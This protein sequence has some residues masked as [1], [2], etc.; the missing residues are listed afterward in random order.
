MFVQIVPDEAA[1]ERLWNRRL[2]VY[3]SVR[4]TVN[5]PSLVNRKRWMQGVALEFIEKRIR[6]EN[7]LIY[8]VHS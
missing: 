2:S 6:N 7:D 8:Y 3:V 1:N 5:H 4:M